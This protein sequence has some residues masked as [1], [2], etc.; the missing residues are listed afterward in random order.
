MRREAVP[1]GDTT[2]L[3]GRPMRL[4]FDRWTIIE[5][6]RVSVPEIRNLG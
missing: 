2:E 4:S 5:W 6:A 1:N 3:E